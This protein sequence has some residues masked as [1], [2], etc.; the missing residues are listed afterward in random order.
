MARFTAERSAPV[1]LRLRRLLL[2]PLTPLDPALTSKTQ[3]LALLLICL[4]PMTVA[5]GLL[6]LNVRAIDANRALLFGTVLV[7]MT[8]YAAAYGLARFGWYTAAA[9]ITV[10]MPSA[11]IVAIFML[12]GGTSFETVLI[13]L[14]LPVWFSSVLFPVQW[15]A[16]VAVLNLLVIL[17]I[18][19][20]SPA[21]LDTRIVIATFSMVAVFSACLLMLSAR[22]TALRADRDRLLLREMTTLQ[23]I[24]EAHPDLVAVVR[25]DRV[26]YIN[27]TGMRLLGATQ[28][29]QV[30]GQTLTRFLDD[31]SREGLSASLIREQSGNSFAYRLQQTLVTLDGGRVPVE[32][33]SVPITV[34]GAIGTQIIAR[35]IRPTASA[36]TG[37]DRSHG[38]QRYRQLAQTAR[39]IIITHDLTGKITYINPA[40]IEISG[41]SESDI[42]QVN[43]LSLLTPDRQAEAIARQQ[44]RLEGDHDRFV[45]ETEFLNR[46]GQRIPVEVCTSLIP[47]DAAAGTEANVLLIARDLRERNRSE[48]SLRHSEERFSRV[49]RTDAIA[50]AI[51]SEQQ[52]RFVDFN[53]AFC[54]LTG[55]SAQELSGASSLELN[56][57]ANVADR[58]WLAE[59]IRLHGYIDHAE[60]ETR[61]K[62][63]EIR[64]VLASVSRIS[65]EDEP[66]ILVI[67][68]D[69]TERTQ[70][71]RALHDN[72]TRYRMISE[73]MSD[74]AYGVRVN[75]DG[76]IHLA[77]ITDSFMRI[78]GYS[79]EEAKDYAIWRRLIHPLDYALFRQRIRELVRGRPQVTEF[80]VIT[81]D[82]RV[83]WLRE[84]ARPEW[85]SEHS[86]VVAVYGAAQDITEPVEAQ[87]AVQTHALQQAVV[88]ELG[89][90]ALM[91]PVEIDTLLHEAALLVAQVLDVE[92]CSVL[93]LDTA[94]AMLTQRAGI[95]WPPSEI[96]RAQ[97]AL[98]DATAIAAY[99]LKLEE[100]INL[101]DVRS[102]PRFAESEL[103][104]RFG[105]ASGVLVVIHGQDRALGVLSA[106]STRLRV[107]THDDLNFLQAIAN[108]IGTFT[109]HRR[110]EIAE[111]EQRDFAEALSEIAAILNS[112]LEPEQVFERILDSTARVVPHDAASIMLVDNGQARVVCHRGLVERGSM[113][114][115]IH[116]ARFPIESNPLLQEMIR[117]GQAVMVDHTYQQPGWHQVKGNEWIQAYLGAPIF[118]RGQLLGI[119]NLDSAR[120]GAFDQRY[121]NRLMAVANQASIAVHN[122]QRARELEQRVVE[123][124]EQLDQER[125]RLQTLVDSTGDGIFY[126]ENLQIRYANPAFCRMIGYSLDE[127]AAMT[128]ADLIDGGLTPEQ[129]ALWGAVREQLLDG[130][131]I[132]TE[133]RLR[134]KT[135]DPIDV[136]LTL[137]LVASS[138]DAIRTVVIT[139]DIRQEKQIQAQKTRFIADASHEL[140]TPIATLH[141]RLYLMRR[142]P[143]RAPEHIAQLE[144]VADRMNRLVEDLLDMSRFESGTIPIQRRPAVLQSIVLE[145]VELQVDQAQ[146]KRITL[147][148]DL[149]AAPLNVLVDPD[150]I[151]QVI[152]N[153]VTNAINYTPE[154]GHV[155]VRVALEHDA[156]HKPQA[157]IHVSDNGSGIREQ[158]L[159]N[160]FQP[161]YRGTAQSRGTGLGLS[162]AREIV[163]MHDGQIEV[164]STVDVGSTFAIRLPL[165]AELAAP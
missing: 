132:R 110:A 130:E 136:A 30:I 35:R 48:E 5:V 97:V 103:V 58:W 49:F 140:R 121:A 74:Y 39:D 83:R 34:E 108:V 25:D 120:I 151:H 52:Q 135:G 94:R 19:F 70:A 143:S 154:G 86:Q 26:V 146:M 106:Y 16:G 152:T 68:Q 90:H 11:I 88:A 150:R 91:R 162:I 165:L 123:R 44:R 64:H 43:I 56:L 79:T 61:T 141:N 129:I 117:T 57:W 145:A 116:E 93:E 67:L 46:D 37:P 47:A 127:L 15:A 109:E 32:V 33:I 139:R 51:I 81:R 126:T 114:Q 115:I 42:G 13:F 122:A 164:Q 95:G 24:L 1:G 8:A 21:L 148:T 118:Y 157:V 66:C 144:R 12:P 45:Y 98:D 69:I 77:W 40:G 22:A 89:Q 9:L 31:T 158:D 119:I 6:H 54:R 156:D 87:Q 85:D 18:P 153:L 60:L 161:F 65:W 101:S 124:T 82:G 27:A 75:A 59:Q 137:S 125:R 159:P 84:Y 50:M 96:G 71:L 107:F 29:D 134:R 78:T 100:P 36:H 112:T 41:R 73:M 62:S 128:T 7:A 105:I 147:T 113:A 20:V 133:L 102:D 23:T 53:R 138:G 76:E 155:T 131:V 149:E 99:A 160:I 2:D 80:R 163:L 63:G 72:E 142:D 28:P 55:Y 111:A 4:L 92:F 17:L 3:M 104:R 14:L 38:E 10:L